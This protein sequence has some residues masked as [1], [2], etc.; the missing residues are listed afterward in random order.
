MTSAKS[1][2]D[3][4][5][6]TKRA[7]SAGKYKPIKTRRIFEEICASIRSQ[8]IAGE[9]NPGDRLPPERELAEMFAVSRTAVREALRSLEMFGL[10]DLRKGSRGGAFVVESGIGVISQSFRDMVDFGRVSL[11]T[12]MDARRMIGEVAIRAA[13][14]RT[15]P[16]DFGKLIPKIAVIEALTDDGNIPERRERIVDFTNELAE[17]AGNE[18]FSA[19]TVAMSEV[20]RAY[21]KVTG[22]VP[23]LPIAPAF[24][25][26]LTA[27][28]QG[29]VEEAVRVHNEISDVSL[30]HLV[31]LRDEFGHPA[32]NRYMT[33]NG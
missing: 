26:I 25:E 11:E 14:K 24:R 6:R 5:K 2:T 17:F 7:P 13:A 12:F 28:K 4:K 32:G 10:I 18:V 9:L 8:M 33:R 31:R 3:E 22:P 27:L 30:E 21:S 16:G 20:I 1:S 23:L 19:I 29:D 15:D